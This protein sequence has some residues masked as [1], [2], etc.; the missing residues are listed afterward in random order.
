MVQ[1]D[2]Y[3]ILHLIICLHYQAIR[4]PQQYEVLADIDVIFINQTV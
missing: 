2:G 4:N 1:T 3:L